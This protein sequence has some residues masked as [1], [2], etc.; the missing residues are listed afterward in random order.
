MAVDVSGTTKTGRMALS[1]RVKTAPDPKGGAGARRVSEV[2][3]E[4]LRL[5]VV[6]ADRIGIDMAGP[7]G[8]LSVDLTSGSLLGVRVDDV[9]LDLGGEELTYRGKMA[10]DQ[11][12]QLRFAVVTRAVERGVEGAPTKIKGTLSG[13]AVEPG[14]GKQA[15]AVQVEFIESGSKK[16]DLHGVEMTEGELTTEAGTVVIRRASIGG[17]LETDKDGTVRF[18][19]LGPMN[20]DLAAI[21]WR[22]AGGAQITAQGA[23]VLTGVLVKGSWKTP[24]PVAETEAKKQPTRVL[25]LDELS[26]ARVTSDNLRYVDGNLDVHLGRDEDRKA[27]KAPK[28][29]LLEINDVLVRGMHWD[30]VAGITS[31]TVDVG[32]SKVDAEAM[33]SQAP[34]A[35]KVV[36]DALRIRAAV[37]IGSMHLSFMEGGKLVARVKGAS[38]EIGV[39]EGEGDD[40][41]HAKFSGLDSGRIEIGP[42]GID[43]KGLDLGVLSIDTMSWHGAS[44]GLIVSKGMGSVDLG[45]VHVDAHVDLHPPGH[46]G[47]RFRRLVLSKFVIDETRGARTVGADGRFR[48]QAQP[49]A[50]SDPRPDHPD[51]ARQG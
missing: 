51:R 1:A 48:D 24:K 27:G 41:Y 5:A 4:W 21:D 10:V 13:P 15:S 9:H 28:R 39:G 25:D 17:H 11:L 3:V 37:G 16:I 18:D 26:I 12:D 47:G 32:K 20:I 23:T 33:L 44:I 2:V 45:G 22:T 31:G 50:G 7:D 35:G 19:R 6:D 40:L 43:V 8:R 42:D 38:G 49:D 34:V 46:A 29:D 30:D 14:A 36:A